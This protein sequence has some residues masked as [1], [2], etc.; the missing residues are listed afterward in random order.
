MQLLEEL[1]E[2]YMGLLPSALNIDLPSESFATCNN[3]SMCS[4]ERPHSSNSYYSVD[5]KC[6]TFHPH[7]PN[8][9]IGYILSAK[10]SGMKEGQLR[11]QEIIKNRKGVFPSGIYPSKK[12]QS[13]YRHYGSQV[14][15]K[16]VSLLC[17]F[18]V[19]ESGLCSI[20]KSRESICSTYFCVHTGGIQGRN[21]WMT[22]KDYLTHVQESLA[23]YCLQK[24]TFK[25]KQH[26]GALL[27]SENN[28]SIEDFDEAPPSFEQ[29]ANLWSNYKG[30]EIEFYKDCFEIV[31]LLKKDELLCLLGIK[32]E[33][34]LTDIISKNLEL[35]DIPTRLIKNP[36]SVALKG[37]NNVWRIPLGK[38]KVGITISDE[39]VKLF[40]GTLTVEEIAAKAIKQG[41]DV[42]LL[43]ELV[44][45]LYHHKFF[46]KS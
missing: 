42:T 3:C 27:E 11:I 10:D 13:L 15:G 1:P 12:Y 32:G 6:C 22:I 30:R 46:V 33:T 38:S 5:T 2:L 45:L 43:E 8:Y 25:S 39:L 31:R 16:T 40:D 7:L 28:I 41:I 19:K 17:P 9:L 36:S 35:K 21:L 37:E 34:L 26:E 24:K 14:F 20:W 18:Y 23:Q 29:Y 44:Y 4:E